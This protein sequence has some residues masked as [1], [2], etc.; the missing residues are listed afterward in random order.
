MFEE[1]INIETAKLAKEK[2]FDEACRDFHGTWDGYDGVHKMDNYNR[3]NTSKQF[4]APT[5]GL[6]QKW[7][8]EVK[9]ID[10][11]AR[12]CRY[13]GDMTTSY[14]QPYANGAV[15]N[16]K[17]YKTYEEALETGLIASLKLI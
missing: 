12:G 13:A 1:L 14:Y 11:E 16:L 9:S 6:L 10:V 3:H 2:G 17:Q 7:L 4:S 8:R 15:V 5:Q